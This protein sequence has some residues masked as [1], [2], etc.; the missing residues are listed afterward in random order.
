MSTPSP[1]ADMPVQELKRTTSPRSDDSTH[2]AEKKETR[3]LKQVDEEGAYE[4][5]VEE[6]QAAPQ[7]PWK[8]KVR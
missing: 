4:E 7:V 6:V 5:G 3:S 1:L 2:D 8:Y